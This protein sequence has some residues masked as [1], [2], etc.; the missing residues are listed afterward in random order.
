MAHSQLRTL[1]YGRLGNIVSCKGNGS[2][3]DFLK[4]GQ[5]IHKFCLP[6]AV[7]SCNTYDL[8]SSHVKRHILYRIIGMGLTGHCHMF[9]LQNRFSRLCFLLVYAEAYISAYHHSG[10]LFLGGICNLNRSY[11]FSLAQDGTSVCHLHDLVELMGDKEDGLAF[12]CKVFHDLHQLAD[13]LRGQ[14]RCRLIKDQHLVI[15]VKHLQDF[16]TLLHSHCNI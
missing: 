1:S 2:P 9:N 11:A 16:R 8:T 13:L 15:P 5:S 4:S 14:N 12:L 10:K 3:A 7:N 6:I